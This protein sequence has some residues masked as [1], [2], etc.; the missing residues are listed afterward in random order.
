MKLLRGEYQKGDKILA[1]ISPDP[2][3]DNLVF[4]QNDEA[5]KK[6]KETIDAELS[7]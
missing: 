6:A 5:V 4:Y 7:K 1:D 2:E 3:A